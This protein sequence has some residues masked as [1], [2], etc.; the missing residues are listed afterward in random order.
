M[1]NTMA[2]SDLTTRVPWGP[3]E[4]RA[5]A[6]TASFDVAAPSGNSGAEPQRF[7]AT[8]AQITAQLIGRY[9][10]FQKSLGS[11]MYRGA[12]QE[13]QPISGAPTN[14]KC[15]SYWN[16]PVVRRVNWTRA[17]TFSALQEWEGVVVAITP[18]HIVASL[19][20]LTAGKSRATEEALIP[21]SEINE[22]DISKLAV[23]RVFRWAIGYQRIKTGTKRRIS[24]M[25]FRDLPQWTKRDF[26]E[27]Q[28]DAARLMRFLGSDQ[29]RAEASVAE[30][31]QG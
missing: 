12:R 14:E 24:N 25:I 2:V 7:D 23:G 27:A 1:T 29:S 10:D 13:V 21:L 18:D 6:S 4:G 15:H 30:S 20:D 5:D 16:A 19:V 9:V 11:A 26:V 28:A 3:T 8:K 22:H 31:G 17:N